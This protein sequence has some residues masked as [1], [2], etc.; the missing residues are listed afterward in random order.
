MG[1]GSFSQVFHGVDTNDGSRVAIKVVKYSSL[2]SRVAEGLLKNEVS[3]LKELDHPNVLKCLDNFSSKNN[4]YII[5][6]LCE[7]GDLE[8]LVG[9]HKKFEE[10]DIGKIVYDVYQGLKYLN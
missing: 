1:E 8:K 7:N 3:I 10:Q 5:C 9:R 4:C 6:E 2:S